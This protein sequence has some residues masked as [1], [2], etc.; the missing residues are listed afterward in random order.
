MR[1]Q[2]LNIWCKRHIRGIVQITIRWD[3]T[4]CKISSYYMMNTVKA[5]QQIYWNTVQ[6]TKIVEWRY[7]SLKWQHSESDSHC[8]ITT[9]HKLLRHLDNNTV[10]VAHL[11]TIHW[12]MSVCPLH[13]HCMADHHTVHHLDFSHATDRPRHTSHCTLTTLTTHSTHSPLEQ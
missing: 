4:K 7:R 9:W 1:Q 8:W 13:C 10:Q 5:S 12:H 3:N 6:A 2:H 11:D